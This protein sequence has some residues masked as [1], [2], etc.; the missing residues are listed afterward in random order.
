VR[1]RDTLNKM[2]MLK[3]P[4]KLIVKGRLVRAV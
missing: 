3:M 4:S 1:S 2:G